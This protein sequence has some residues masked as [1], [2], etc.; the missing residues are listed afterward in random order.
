GLISIVQPDESGLDA[1]PKYDEALGL[2]EPTE[3]GLRRAMDRLFRAYE[4]LRGSESA[5]LALDRFNVEDVMVN[6]IYADGLRD[7]AVLCGE[8]G[9]QRLARRFAERANQTELALL[10]KCWDPERRVFWDLVGAVE[11]PAT[12]LTVTSL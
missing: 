3:A 11:Q 6:S 10:E 1:S 5:L 8:G 2:V 9:E 7:M 12:V 4:P